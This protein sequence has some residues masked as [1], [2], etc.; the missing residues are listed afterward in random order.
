M[1]ALKPLDV[2]SWIDQG[3]A[4][5]V[6][7]G[8][9][10]TRS[11]PRLRAELEQLQPPARYRVVLDLR[12]LTFIDETGI[13]VLIGAANRARA[14]RGRTV[15]VAPRDGVARRLSI[16]GLAAVLPQVGSLDEAFAVLSS[17]LPLTD[18]HTNEKM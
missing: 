5:V 15:V 11:A 17:A 18:S 12:N 10:D 4:V 7:G 1:D 14:G 2:E 16:M 3:R 13:G 8:D 9:L 6:V